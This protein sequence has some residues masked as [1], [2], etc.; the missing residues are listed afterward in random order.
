MKMEKVWT[1]DDVKADWAR[2]KCEVAYVR[3]IVAAHQLMK[4]LRRQEQQ[5]L[6]VASSLKYS[7]DQPRVSAGQ[8]GG[9]QWTDGGGGGH[10]L[11]DATPDS[12]WQPGSQVANN[13]SGD[14]SN[15]PGIGH[16]DPPKDP[17]NVPEQPPKVPAERPS[18]PQVR[19][20]IIKEV[21]KY[22]AKWA[23]KNLVTL[24]RV[25]SWIYEAYPYIKS[26]GDAP[27]SLEDLQRAVS[28]PEAGYD[29]HHIVE[30]TPADNEGYTRDVIDGRDNLV[31]VPTLKHWEITGWY[32]RKDEAFG[33]KSPRE[34]LRGKSWDEKMAMGKKALVKHGVLKP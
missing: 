15:K 5:K 31:R 3:T 34:Y 12:F 17:P 30:Q 9:G 33:M 1:L 2:V 4:I 27:K 14:G 21:A 26:Y 19:T 28:Q 20:R 6:L 25:G 13:D 16:N 23:V 24:V 29:I 18:D 7:R 10:V 11:S 32:A 22:A 8:S